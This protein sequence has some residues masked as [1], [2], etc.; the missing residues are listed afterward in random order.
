M[1][2]EGVWSSSKVPGEAEKRASHVDIIFG[3]HNMYRL[4][5][6]IN[7]VRHGGQILEIVDEECEIPEALP[8]KRQGKLRLKSPLCM[9]VIIFVHIV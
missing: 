8:I 1:L 5:Q 6:F 2:W 3:T 9:G 4:P 7:E